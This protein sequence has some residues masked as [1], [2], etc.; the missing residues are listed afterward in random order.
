MLARRGTS[1]PIP[2]PTLMVTLQQSTRETVVPS[3]ALRSASLAQA[4]P[5]TPDLTAA[6]SQARTTPSP[7][8]GLLASSTTKT[9]D[10]TRETTSSTTHIREE[11][12]NLSMR[13]FWTVMI[14]F[15]TT[16]MMVVRPTVSEKIT[17]KT[18]ITG[19]VTTTTDLAVATT[20]RPLSS[21][22]TK[23]SCTL[24]PALPAAFLTLA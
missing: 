23:T 8:L 13:T 12:K 15:T 9:A 1:A 16:I 10:S 21:P 14:H 6:L 20:T 22:T 7:L 2:N 3:Q 4:A 5:T 18:N 19:A 24:T 11:N 17:A